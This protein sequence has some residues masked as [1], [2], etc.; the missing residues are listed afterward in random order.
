MSSM[1]PGGPKRVR[2]DYA[3]QHEAF[4]SLLP[5]SGVLVRQCSDVHGHADWFLLKL[6]EPFDY[7]LKIGEPF[8]FRLA[9]VEHF[10]LRSRWEGHAV[11]AAE[12]TAVFILLV[13]GQVDVPD[14]FD[15]MSYIHLAWGTSTTEP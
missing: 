5:R 10:L 7:Q 8:Q 15:P 9:R 4:A 13:V 11:G 2:V 1:E 14:V 3:D 6:D 12:P